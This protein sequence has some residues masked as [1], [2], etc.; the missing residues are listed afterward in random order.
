MS[1]MS[2]TNRGSRRG[3]KRLQLSRI[4]YQRRAVRPRSRFSEHK[5]II[6]GIR[7]LYHL[8]LRAPSQ[9]F[10]NPPSIRDLPRHTPYTVLSKTL[11]VTQPRLLR[12][13]ITSRPWPGPATLRRS[14]SASSRT[15]FELLCS[16][17]SAMVRRTARRRCLRGLPRAESSPLDISR[18]RGGNLGRWA[19]RICLILGEDGS[20]N[21]LPVSFAMQRFI[22]FT[23]CPA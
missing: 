19:G 15:G 10:T 22:A 7:L 20:R 18:T 5:Y 11:S 12:R 21:G 16:S 14:Q 3:T 2:V 4:P 17:Q 1:R 13:L 23:F 8:L 6:A 9:S